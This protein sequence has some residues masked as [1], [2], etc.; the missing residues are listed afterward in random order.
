[1]IIIMCN[2][3]VGQFGLSFE[4]GNAVGDTSALPVFDRAVNIFLPSFNFYQR[5]F[6]KYLGTIYSSKI[7][8]WPGI[9]VL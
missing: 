8:I 1:M 2:C 7:V 9:S 5:F 3:A 6:F 4:F